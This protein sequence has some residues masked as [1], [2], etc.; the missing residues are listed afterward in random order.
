MH[1]LNHFWMWLVKKCF[2]L[3]RTHFESLYLATLGVFL[4][5]QI[6]KSSI[7]TSFET[8]DNHVHNGSPVWIVSPFSHVFDEAEAKLQ[9]QSKKTNDSRRRRQ[10]K[11]GKAKQSKVSKAKLERRVRRAEACESKQAMRSRQSAGKAKQTRD[12]GKDSKIFWFQLYFLFARKHQKW[13]HVTIN[14]I[15]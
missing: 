14:L 9:G 11:E 5:T 15:G 13:M 7:E 3:W 6:M 2:G 10:G 4:T 12:M 8:W 1:I